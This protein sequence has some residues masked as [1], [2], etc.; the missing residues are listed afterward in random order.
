[1]S[2][3]GGRLQDAGP[4][5]ASKWGFKTTHGQ[6]FSRR[7]GFSWSQLPGGSGLVNTILT[8]LFCFQPMTGC[9]DV[10]SRNDAEFLHFRRLSSGLARWR[11]VGR[12]GRRALMAHGCDHLVPGLHDM[13]C[14]TR[15]LPSM[16]PTRTIDILCDRASSKKAGTK[17]HPR[18]VGQVLPPSPRTLRHSA[19]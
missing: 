4:E 16:Q 11:R 19:A 7:I 5:L 12:G 18:H 8:A 6:H 1:M 9:Q 17:P 3:G 2:L 13:N 10:A 15:I 14:T